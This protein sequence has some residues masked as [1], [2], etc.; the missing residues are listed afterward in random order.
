MNQAKDLFLQAIEKDEV[1]KFLRGDRIY[2][3]PT[4]KVLTAYFMPTP[5]DWEYIISDGV[6]EVYKE[7]PELNIK[8]LFEDAILYL[9]TSDNIN[10][11]AVANVIFEQLMN[12]KRNNAPFTLNK[13]KLLPVL[14]TKLLEKQDDLKKDFS[15]TGN[16]EPEGLWSEITRI[17]QK[18]KKETGTGIL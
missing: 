10:L 17:D 12:E 3:A 11:Y 1:H 7:K 2:K 14:K 18:L 16:G 5:T 8:Q 9:T 4:S 13:E 15:W 6:Y